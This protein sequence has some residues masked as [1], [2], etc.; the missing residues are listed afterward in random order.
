[1][2]IVDQYLT[3]IAEFLKSRDGRQLQTFLRVEPPLPSKFIQL[4]LEVKKL[5]PKDEQEVL[6]GRNDKL[7][8]HIQKLIPIPEN[9]ALDSNDLGCAWPSFQVL[10]REYL[11]F[12][13]D[14]DFNDLLMTHTLLSEVT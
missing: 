10:V 2:L 4:G 1:M 13:R 14:V 5:F 3:S 7:D 9:E 6:D 11:K 12:W 8:G